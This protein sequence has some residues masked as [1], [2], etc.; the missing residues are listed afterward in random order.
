MIET[1]HTAVDGAPAERR[2]AGTDRRRRLMYALVYGGLRPRRRSGR[3]VDDHARPV[4][5]W[6]GPG[7]WASAIL[8][9]VLC[10][11]DA[12]LTLSLMT[13]GAVEANPLMAPLV[14]GDMLRFAV[15]KLTLTGGGILTLVALANFRVFRRIRAGA[16]VHTIL[17]AYLVLVAYEIA[18]VSANA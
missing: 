4:V 11:A 13:T 15:V 5:D 8:V 6:H 10:V 17:F 3:R 16:L 1:T 18:L 9:L 14:D 12:L 7:L 2:V